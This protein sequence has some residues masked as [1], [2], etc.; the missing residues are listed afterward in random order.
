LFIDNGKT[1]SIGILA[2]DL[3]VVFS[4]AVQCGA[5]PE[6]IRRALSRDP[7]GQAQGP[8][9]VALDLLAESS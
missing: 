9:G 3:G 2:H 4:I 1:S 7:A 6:T 8:L 5:D